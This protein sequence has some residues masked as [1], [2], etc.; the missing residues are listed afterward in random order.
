ML[1]FCDF[2]L[3][4]AETNNI[5]RTLLAIGKVRRDTPYKRKLSGSLTE[6]NVSGFRNREM[7]YANREMQ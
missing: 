6:A 4:L 5:S 7:Q 3:K 1:F 2:E